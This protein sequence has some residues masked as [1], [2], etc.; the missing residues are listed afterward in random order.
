MAEAEEKPAYQRVSL[1]DLT[2]QRH[3]SQAKPLQPLGRLCL[4]G[5]PHPSIG[6]WHEKAVRTVTKAA[7][8]KDQ[9]AQLTGLL[10]VVQ[11]GWIHLVEGS[12][13]S[14][15]AYLS[16]LRAEEQTGGAVRTV[17]VASC[18]DDVPRRTFSRWVNSK[19]DV[20]RN[21]YM[22]VGAR[23]ARSNYAQLPPQSR[24]SFAQR[25]RARSARSAIL[26][27]QCH[28]EGLGCRAGP[29]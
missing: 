17:K 1:H 9:N 10:L 8:P 7:D 11:T 26:R 19:I 20:A 2:L 5:G 6:S 24:S 4:V 13:P 14:L 16:L 22:E 23:T 18:M 12:T 27:P 3:E 28:Y 25:V 29:S 15:S 21:N